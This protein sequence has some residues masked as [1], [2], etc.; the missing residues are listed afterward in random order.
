ME[1]RRQ[2]MKKMESKLT[3]EAELLNQ[4]LSQYQYCISR[5]K[6]L[7]NRRAEIVKE[8][9][10]PLRAIRLDGMPRSGSSKVGCAALSFRLD[11]V[12]TRIKE[13]KENA[14]KVLV[15]IMN[16]IDFLP[17]SSLERAILENR[18]LDR[19]NWEQVCRENHISRTPATKK[20]RKALY[21]LLEFK[22]IKQILEEYKNGLQNSE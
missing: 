4:Y 8:F 3:D 10:N 11:E 16:I 7:G 15:N 6:S 2:E 5:K 13:Q 18:Y 19:Y 14:E 22:K 12:D 1:K 20:W 21:M 9:D 17:E